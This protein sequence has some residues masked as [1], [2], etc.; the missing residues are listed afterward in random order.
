MWKK[1]LLESVN[2]YPKTTLVLDALDECE[3]CGDL[4]DMIE[5]LL[6][7]SERPLKIFISSRD[8][9][10][11]RE[12]FKSLR[13]IEI[14]AADNQDDVKKFLDEKVKRDGWSESVL[15]KIKETLLERSE[16]M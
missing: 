15:K 1:Q 4:I 9:T 5:E 6:S 14:Q 11:I 3:D 12:R 8:D 2:L 10:Y 7:K 16:G 13:N